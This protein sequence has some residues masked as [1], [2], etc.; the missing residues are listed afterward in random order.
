MQEQIRLQE[1]LENQTN[2][3][4]TRKR[5]GNGNNNEHHNGSM[6]GTGATNTRPDFLETCFKTNKYQLKMNILD[7]DEGH[8]YMDSKEE[9]TYK[10][11]IKFQ[12]KIHELRV[13]YV[14][15]LHYD[16]FI[17]VGA[18]R[19]FYNWLPS[20]YRELMKNHCF[21]Y[22][23]SKRRGQKDDS[24]RKNACQSIW[25]YVQPNLRTFEERNKTNSAR[26]HQ[27]NTQHYHNIHET[28]PLA[29]TVLLSTNTSSTNTNNNNK[30][31]ILN[32]FQLP[33]TNTD[34]ENADDTD[35]DDDDAKQYGFGGGYNSISTELYCKVL[36]IHRTP[37][38][39]KYSHDLGTNVVIH[40]KGSVDNIPYKLIMFEAYR[41][42]WVHAYP[43]NSK[44]YNTAWN[45]R[46]G[47]KKRTETATNAMSNSTIQLW[48]DLKE[49]HIQ[50]VHGGE[51]A[52]QQKKIQKNKE[53]EG[54]FLVLP[55]LCPT[56]KR[57]EQLLLMSLR[58]EQLILPDF[59]NS[60]LG[61]E[62]LMTDF[63]NSADQGR[64]SDTNQFCSVNIP[65][66]FG[67]ATSWEEVL[68]DRMTIQS[69]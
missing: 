7:S 59:Y 37:N 6:T 45:T 19:R 1:S 43:P 21:A 40:H 46:R 9:H 67:T 31:E 49:Y 57:L 32:Y 17:V 54:S 64:I 26:I 68:T 22:G 55:L 15:Y 36:G 35:N 28:I 58:L 27:Y 51:E 4:T 42:G 61:K 18:Y 52:I 29:R 66:L 41:R 39:C 10:N 48:E 11:G 38:T 63:W 25:Q 16:E 12:R 3:N 50:V 53:S 2:G 13:L 56:R 30:V 5:N 33:N 69:W 34:R 60:T 20:A 23:Y 44:W 24:S 62:A 8:S 65:E 14:D 47:Q